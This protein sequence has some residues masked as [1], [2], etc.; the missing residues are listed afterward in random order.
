[1]IPT[2]LADLAASEADLAIRYGGGTWKGAEAHFLMPEHLTPVI[3]P[4]LMSRETAFRKSTADWDVWAAS[5]GLDMSSATTVQ[6][7]DY[8]IAIQAALDG[9]RVAMGRMVL[10]KDYL[11]TGRLIRP[12]RM[13]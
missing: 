13:K 3:S 2:Q 1:M 5:V 4:E 8:N 6:L 11:R 9:Q 12:F 7:T 10:V